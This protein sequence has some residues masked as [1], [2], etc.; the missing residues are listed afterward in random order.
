MVLGHDV[1]ESYG[2]APVAGAP[3]AGTSMN[4]KSL[5]RSRRTD[6]FPTSAAC[7]RISA[8]AGSA[9]VGTETTDRPSARMSLTLAAATRDPDA[10]S[11][12]TMPRS[13]SAGVTDARVTETP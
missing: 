13:L 3:P 6:V 8:C 11:P 4:R 2:V 10:G 1:A 5:A 7:A 9:A 12:P